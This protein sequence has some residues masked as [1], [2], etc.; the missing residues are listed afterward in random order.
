MKAKYAVCI[1][2]DEQKQFRWRVVSKTNG[3]NIANGSEGYMR[4]SAVLSMVKALF[5]PRLETQAIELQL[6]R[7]VTVSGQKWLNKHWPGVGY[8]MVEEI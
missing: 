6:A 5:E 2:H 3:S 7:D 4:I 1:Y 8:V